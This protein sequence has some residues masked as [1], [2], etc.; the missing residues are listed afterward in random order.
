MKKTKVHCK[1]E[2]GLVEIFFMVFGRL[3]FLTSQKMTEA[4][5]PLPQSQFT[6]GTAFV[7]AEHTC[8]PLEILEASTALLMQYVL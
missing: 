4:G 6:C 2:E 3:A 7:T 5:K 8:R 1:E